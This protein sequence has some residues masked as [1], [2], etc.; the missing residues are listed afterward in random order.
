MIDQ[1]MC[2]I[3]IER[4][5]DKIFRFC[6]L[7]LKNFH[8]AEECTQEVFF[9]LFKKSPELSISDKLGS[10]LYAAADKI[11]KKCRSKNMINTVDIDEFADIIASKSNSPDKNIL[12]EIYDALEKDDADLFVEYAEADS[13]ERKRIAERLDIT[14]DA[15]YKRIERIKKKLNSYFL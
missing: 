1:E 10:W 12:S 4:Y 9:L 6:L 5:H 11:C 7:Q 14:T 15:L 8:L 3:I 13:D 2:K